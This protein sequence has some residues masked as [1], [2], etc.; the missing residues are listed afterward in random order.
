MCTYPSI[1]E[2][3]FDLPVRKYASR[4]AN[5]LRS[6]LVT[7]QPLFVPFVTCVT[8]LSFRTY[9]WLSLVPTSLSRTLFDEY[10]IYVSCLVAKFML[11]V[12]LISFRNYYIYYYNAI[13]HIFFLKP[14][15]LLTKFLAKFSS[16]RVT[17]IIWCRDDIRW[18]QTRA[19]S[20][21]SM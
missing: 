12:T 5:S 8:H 21:R 13:F 7:L 2:T 1:D 14:K 11:F 3:N 6:G 15:R 18:I 17:L 20:L 19:F 10:L 16:V 4:N 9:L